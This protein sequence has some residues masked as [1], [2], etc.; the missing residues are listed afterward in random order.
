M[1]PSKPLVTFYLTLVLCVLLVPAAAGSYKLEPVFETDNPGEFNRWLGRQWPGS[2][3]LPFVHVH[4]TESTARL[5]SLHVRVTRV[6]AFYDN[7][8]SVI[9]TRRTHLDK[10]TGLI[11]KLSKGGSETPWRFA[12]S[13]SGEALFEHTDSGTVVYDRK[14]RRLFVSHEGEMYDGLGGLFLRGSS[15]IRAVGEWLSYDPAKGLFLDAHGKKVGE[16]GTIQVLDRQ[17][18]VLREVDLSTRI[19][20][21]VSSREEP[22]VDGPHVTHRGARKTLVLD[23]AGNDVWMPSVGPAPLDFSRNR[24]WAAAARADTAYITDLTERM[25]Y[26]V[27]LDPTWS[28]SGAGVGFIALSPDGSTTALYGEDRLGHDYLEVLSNRGVR[29]YSHRHQSLGYVVTHLFTTGLQVVLVGAGCISTLDLDGN[30]QLHRTPAA[31]E[32]WLRWPFVVLTGGSVWRAF[33]FVP[34]PE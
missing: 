2:A 22:W 21:M 25:T 23:S 29:L 5:D 31:S 19:A 12:V 16:E 10:Y 14:G 11:K 15:A 20:I 27:P 26:T 33:K 13:R 6:V 4:M 3:D 8:G 17:G 34:E 1:S 24:R 32:A 9:R 28:D 30:I 18:N 7:D